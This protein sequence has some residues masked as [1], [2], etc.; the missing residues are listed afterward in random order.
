MYKLSYS[1]M[2]SKSCNKSVR[3]V[4]HFSCILYAQYFIFNMIYY[5]KF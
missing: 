2:L 3:N 1:Q 4:E 5:H